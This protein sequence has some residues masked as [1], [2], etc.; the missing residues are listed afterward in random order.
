MDSAFAWVF[1]KLRRR[2][3]LCHIMLRNLYLGRFPFPQ[4]SQSIFI[5]A[6]PTPSKQRPTP[7]CVSERRAK[8][9]VSARAHKLASHLRVTVKNTFITTHAYF[10]ELLLLSFTGVEL[11]KSV[12]VRVDDE[13]LVSDHFC[14][15]RRPG[16]ET[17]KCNTHECPARWECLFAEENCHR[18]IRPTQ[19]CTQFRSLGVK[20]L[21]VF[22]LHDNIVFT[23]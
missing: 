9:W 21:C 19:Y 14:E 20:V 15:G 10:K 2:Y 16:D 23:F 7:L 4:H 5:E 3:V 6:M 13:S 22:H 1:G 11:I 18:P 17:I 8:E 12:C